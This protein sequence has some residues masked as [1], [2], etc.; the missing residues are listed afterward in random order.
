MLLRHPSEFGPCWE[1]PALRCNWEQTLADA[2][3]GT[4]QNL[5]AKSLSC[6]VSFYG[7]VTLMAQL[8]GWQRTSALPPQEAFSR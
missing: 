6:S 7:N 1:P 3:P 2:M 4:S 5:P 8:L